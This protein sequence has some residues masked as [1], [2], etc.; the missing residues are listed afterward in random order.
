MEALASDQRS[1]HAWEATMNKLGPIVTL[2]VALGIAIPT[3]LYAQEGIKGEITKVDEANGKISIKQ[4]PVGT[5]GAGSE[6]GTIRDFKVKDGLLFNAV[7]AGDKVV[8]TADTVDGNLI[9]TKM[10]QQ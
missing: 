9:I 4:A 5:V 7:K 10:Q 3:V 8:F 1:L 6:A 2:A